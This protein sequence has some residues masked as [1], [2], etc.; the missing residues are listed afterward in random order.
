MWPP[1]AVLLS[2]AHGTHPRRVRLR[3]AFRRRPL[4]FLFS[5]K[6]PG[7][8]LKS[9]RGQPGW[10]S[11]RQPKRS[12]L[13][14]LLA[15]ANKRPGTPPAAGVYRPRRAGLS[16][17]FANS[18]VSRALGFGATPDGCDIIRTPLRHRRKPTSAWPTSPF[19]MGNCRGKPFWPLASCLARHLSRP[20]I[21]AWPEIER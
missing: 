21:L 17:A 13:T 2:P 8:R 15:G 4:F 10:M 9:D 1:Y 6:Q 5:K 14:K 7:K 19:K 11:Y 12:S 18:L 3:A 20:A 16:E